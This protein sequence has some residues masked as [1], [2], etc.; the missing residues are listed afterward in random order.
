MKMVVSDNSIN[1]QRHIRFSQP[2]R[3]KSLNL[4]HIKFDLLKI[5]ELYDGYLTPELAKLPLELYVP[6]LEDLKKSNQIFSYTIDEPASRFH[7]DTGNRSFTYTFHVQGTAERT[8]KV[9]KIHV[10]IYKNFY[11]SDHVADGSCCFP[12]RKTV[13]V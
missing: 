11:D 4:A 10:G 5:S 7:T 9:L 12:A 8:A 13:V 6:Y 2:R 3:Q 1:V